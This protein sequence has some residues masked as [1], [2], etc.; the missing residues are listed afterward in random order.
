MSDTTLI[1]ALIGGLIGVSVYMLEQIN[2][3]HKALKGLC[4]VFQDIEDILEKHSRRIC[5]ISL[6][7]VAGYKQEPLDATEVEKFLE[8]L[9]KIGAK[10]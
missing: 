6:I 3:I 7:A 9:K 5:A 8:E 2:S 4:K 10:K 1:Y